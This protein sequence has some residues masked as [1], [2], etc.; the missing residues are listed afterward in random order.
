M[1]IEF[2][3]PTNFPDVYLPIDTSE[4]V[5]SSNRVFKAFFFYSDTMNVLDESRDN[6]KLCIVQSAKD[7]FVIEDSKQ[8]DGKYFVIEELDQ[9]LIDSLHK[10]IDDI[11]RSKRVTISDLH[12]KPGLTN[13]RVHIRDT[14]LIKLKEIQHLVNSKNIEIFKT[15]YVSVIIIW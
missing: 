7:I 11:Q 15:C 8:F 6:T 10:F 3:S 12:L 9:D 13:V 2:L 5:P 14:D 1:D 4:K